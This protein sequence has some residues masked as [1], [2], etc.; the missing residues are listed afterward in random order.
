MI[1]VVYDDTMCNGPYRVEHKTMEAAVES[2]NNDF[3]SLMKELRDE[4]YEPEWI[5]DGHHKLIF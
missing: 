1:T 3:E 2:V 5:R 4:G